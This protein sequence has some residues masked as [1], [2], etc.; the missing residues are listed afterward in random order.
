MPLADG[1]SPNVQKAVKDLM[2][3]L[4]EEEA[5][6]VKQQRA[7]AQPKPHQFQLSPK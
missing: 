6:V 4:D 3:A 5:G 1:K 7:A 2:D